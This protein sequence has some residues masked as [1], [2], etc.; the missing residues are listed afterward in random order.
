MLN[1]AILNMPGHT[2]YEG[3]VRTF[4]KIEYDQDDLSAFIELKDTYLM[5]DSP[6]GNFLFLMSPKKRKGNG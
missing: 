4:S 5:L 1:S 2:S 3:S 6:D